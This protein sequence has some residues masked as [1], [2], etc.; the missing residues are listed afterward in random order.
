MHQLDKTLSSF[1]E[2]NI[3]SFGFPDFHHELVYLDHCVDV[4]ADW[5]HHFVQ[6]IRSD[7]RRSFGNDFLHPNYLKMP[8]F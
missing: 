1:L 4:T 8:Q 3:G 2:L 5:P 6:K 7:F